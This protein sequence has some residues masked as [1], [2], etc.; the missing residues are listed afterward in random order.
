MALPK[1]QPTAQ[2]VAVQDT[3][4]TTDALGRY[5]CST[6]AEATGNG[7]PPFTAVVVV[8]AY[9]AYLA[10]ALHRSRPTARVLLLDAGSFLVGEHMQNLGRIG[11]DVPAPI[12]QDPRGGP[13]AGL[14][15]AVAGQRRV[16]WAGVLPGWQVAVLGRLVP[17]AHRG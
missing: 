15:P 8:G 3:A 5:V 13:R 7:G 14:G 4:F 10:A 12:G 1:L 11:L 9:G 6:W 16:P 17:A 2:Q